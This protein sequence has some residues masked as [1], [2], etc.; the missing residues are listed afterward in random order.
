MAT[1]KAPENE[2][3]SLAIIGAGVA[4]LSLARGLLKYPHISVRVYE[5]RHDI[6]NDGSGFGIGGNGQ[7]AMQLIDSDL[8]ACLERA[9]GVKMVPQ[10][11]FWMATG[12][13][14]GEHISD[15][16]ADPPQK[17]V[18]RSRFL[19]ELR[20]TLPDGLIRTGKRLTAIEQPTN[21]DGKVR[22]TFEHASVV[23]VDGVVGCDGISSTVR[24]YVLGPD[25]PG[26]EAQWRP[27]FNTRIIIPMTEAVS[28]LGWDYCNLMTQHGFIG[29]GGF[30]LTDIEDDGNAMQVIAGFRGEKPVNEVFGKPYVEVEKKFWTERLSGW[31][32]IGERISM[33]VESQD[34][35]F[36]GSGRFHDSTP[37]YWHSRL[38]IAGDAARTFSP[39]RGAG[40]GQSMEDALLLYAVLG[41][42][43]NANEVQKAFQVYDSL[44][45]P[46]RELVAE[47]SQ[48]A[49]MLITGQHPD[50]GLDIEKFRKAVDGYNDWIYDYDLEGVVVQ[51]K[52]LMSEDAF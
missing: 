41:C 27:S 47:E 28:I 45:R 5:A 20:K 37:T 16:Y 49:G 42:V 40:A 46:R 9:G 51:A 4:S 52:K 7:K 14:A 10:A 36:A 13:H 39:A 22:L 8:T 48:I 43:R 38:C 2:Q 44:R 33:V 15:Y 30:C 11:R 25:H 32:W 29:D 1:G 6:G 3:I 18:R 23:F 17:T 24:R 35:V 21:S 19:S 12:P 50:V 26:L 31:G 34:K